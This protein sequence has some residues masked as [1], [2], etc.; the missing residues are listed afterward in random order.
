[1][2]EKKVILSSMNEIVSVV[3]DCPHEEVKFINFLTLM[4]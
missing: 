2:P 3:K 4:D 1:M